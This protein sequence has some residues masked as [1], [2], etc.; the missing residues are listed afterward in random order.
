VQTPRLFVVGGGDAGQAGTQVRPAA[1]SS[2]APPTLDTPQC[3][4]GSLFSSVDRVRSAVERRG[5]PIDDDR[6]DVEIAL[7]ICHWYGTA[8]LN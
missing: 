4:E 1:A 6:L 7:L 2:R 8:V 5:K 3:D